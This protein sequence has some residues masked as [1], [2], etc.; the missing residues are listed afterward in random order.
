MSRTAWS[1]ALNQEKTIGNE[2]KNQQ[3][4]SSMAAESTMDD[5]MLMDGGKQWCTQQTRSARGSRNAVATKRQGQQR[6]TTRPRGS[7]SER[8]CPNPPEGK[9][10]SEG[11]STQHATH[12]N[13]NTVD[14]EARGPQKPNDKTAARG[15]DELEHGA[16]QHTAVVVTAARREEMHDRTRL[17]RLSTLW[18]FLLPLSWWVM[19]FP[20]EFLHRS[21]TQRSFYTAV[22]TQRSFFTAVA[23]QRSF[24]T[25]AQYRF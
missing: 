21:S 2:R 25:A 4:R 9:L 10:S 22:A 24:H 20:A 13:N 15:A 18:F 12:D 14:D 3:S 17:A 16:Q 5:S 8:R 11:D 23:T 1:A 19:A 6:V 7:E